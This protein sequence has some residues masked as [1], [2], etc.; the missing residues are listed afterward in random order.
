[1]NMRTLL[2]HLISVGILIQICVASSG[3]INSENEILSQKTIFGPYNSSEKSNY[4]ELVLVADTKIFKSFDSDIQKVHEF[5]KDLIN[6]VN[7]LFAPLNIFIALTDVVI[8]T[9]DDQINITTNGD[10]TLT[11]F[12]QYRRQ[13]LAIDHPNDYAVLVTG[14]TFDYGIIENTLKK[15]ICTYE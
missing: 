9:K 11:N 8:W 5:S 1:M 13:S 10:Q 2:L 15:P 3:S 12:L 6:H 14:Q 7:S 4:I